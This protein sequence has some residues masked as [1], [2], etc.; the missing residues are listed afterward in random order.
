MLY[1]AVFT[2]L[3]VHSMLATIVVIIIGSVNHECS[4]SVNWLDR[5]FESLGVS[6]QETEFRNLPRNTTG[7]QSG[8]DPTHF[9]RQLIKYRSFITVL[10]VQP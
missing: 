3:L 5:N 7:H 1:S 9:H 4:G 10:K 2:A 8:T 6:L